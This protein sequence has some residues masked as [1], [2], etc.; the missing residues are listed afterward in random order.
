M[1]P[2]EKALPLDTIPAAP[3]DER[4]FW[5][6]R[7]MEARIK[8]AALNDAAEPQVVALAKNGL[9]GSEISRRTGVELAIVQRMIRKMKADEKD[10]A[11]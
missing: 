6:Q 3:H 1:R 10:A 8:L 4:L 9:S 5:R 2:K 11:A 7:F